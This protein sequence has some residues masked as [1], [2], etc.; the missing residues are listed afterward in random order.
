[1]RTLGSELSSGELELA[2][3]PDVAMRVRTALGDPNVSVEE[4]ARLVAAEPVLAARLIKI[5]NSAL[6]SGRSGDAVKDIRTAVTRLG[7][8][9]VRNTAIAL[10]MSQ[11]MGGESNPELKARLGELW[12]HSVRVG[13][14][15]YV[16]ARTNRRISADEAMLAGLLHDIGKIYILQRAERY[17]GLFAAGEAFEQIV[18]DW[19]TGVGSAILL[20]WKFSP[21]MVAV[22]EEHEQRERNTRANADLV[23]VVLV[24]N[25][26]ANDDQEGEGISDWATLPAAQRLQLADN[27]AALILADSRDRL[28]SIINA[29]R[30]VG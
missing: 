8:N 19:H 11:T 15:A 23:D 18:G 9:M 16:I 26:L 14:I 2:G 24:A 20:G 5:A 22:A 30:G 25:L 10:A 12:Q 6:L 13:A 21:E 3:F 27:S 7:F 29:L 17:P 4:V 28:E 1:V